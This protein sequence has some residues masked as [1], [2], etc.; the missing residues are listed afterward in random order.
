M[1]EEDLNRAFHDVIVR[2][3]PPPSMDSGLALEEARRV[4]KRRRA[5]WAGIAV[6]TLV[7][8]G[9]GAGPALF[10]HHNGGSV[11]RMVAGDPTPSTLVST[12]QKV[13]TPHQA[14]TPQPASTL[15]PTT[16]KTDD[17]WPEGQTDRT[18]SAGPRAARAVTLMNDLTSAVPDGFTTPDLK[19][20]SGD[21]MRWPQAQYA[22]SDGELDYWEY[23]ASIPVQKGD[24]VGELMVQSTTP[25]GKPA[26]DLCKLAKKFWG[27]T[28]TCS[29]MNVSGKKVGVVTTNGRGSY[30]QWAAYRYDDGT[31]MYFAQT[32][33]IEG[34]KSLTQPI[35]TPRQL[36]ELVVT[37]KFKISA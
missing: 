9:V 34:R 6:A 36:A 37:P 16:R 8:G 25:D 1:N 12:P 14:S 28:G 27:G 11:G 7:V 33:Q 18:A 2:S 23:K 35:F 20:P 13:S 19:F 15:T 21:P 22:S 5:A 10:A 17:P 30:D 29:I 26:G 3:T 4:R 31:V 32:K 24:R